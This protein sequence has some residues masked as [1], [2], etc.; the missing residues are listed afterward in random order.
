MIRPLA[1]TALLALGVVGCGRAT[2]G[3]SASLTSPGSS[4]PPA[5]A[6]APSPAVPTTQPEAAR[7]PLPAETPTEE[8]GDSALERL[9]QM[10]ADQQLPGGRWKAGT[11]YLPIVPAQPTSV[12]PGKVEV[13]EVFWYACP[14]CFDLEPYIQSWLKKKPAYVEFVRIPVMWGPVHRAHA[15]LFYTLQAL[16][17]SDLDEKVFET[18]HDE[19]NM[20][21]GKD[22]SQTLDMQQKFAVAHGLSADAFKTAYNSFTVSSNLARAEELTAR[23]HVE[24]VP[25]IIVNGKYVTD[26]GK[27]G[28][29]TELIELISDLVASEKRH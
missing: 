10:P 21:V 7:A 22:D 3:S 6:L 27:A 17:R 5:A 19:H 16:Q 4:P 18:I 9:A 14:H 8:R 12:G 2:P 25:L 1:L 20:L 26:V 28:G 23:Y 15:H 11:S 24:G 13:I 29:L